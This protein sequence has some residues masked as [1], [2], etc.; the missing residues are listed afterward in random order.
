MV[1]AGAEACHHL[2][3]RL[4]ACWRFTASFGAAGLLGPSTGRD[5]ALGAPAV[6]LGLSPALHW[7][8]VFPRNAAARAL[9]RQ[10]KKGGKGEE[11]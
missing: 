3:V 9:I 1:Q 10:L 7:M 4:G 5:A 11:N 2:C 6:A 8:S